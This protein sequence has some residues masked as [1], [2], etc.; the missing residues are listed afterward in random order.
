ME[1]GE[2]EHLG[3]VAYE[4]YRNASRGVS[5]VSG[6]ELPTWADQADEIRGAW[7][8]AAQAVQDAL[9]EDGTELRF[10]E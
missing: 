4:G 5:L 8:A 1:I 2:H 10:T 6:Q 9:P 3:R 7:C